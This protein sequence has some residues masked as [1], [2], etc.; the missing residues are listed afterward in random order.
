MRGVRWAALPRLHRN[1]R[2]HVCTGTAAAT[3]A[4]GLRSHICTGRGLA[5]RCHICTG[6]RLAAAT[7]EPGQDV[8]IDCGALIHTAVEVDVDCNRDAVVPGGRV[9]AQMWAG[10]SPLAWDK[11]R[12]TE[13][14]ALALSGTRSTCWCA[15]RWPGTIHPCAAAHYTLRN[16]RGR[17]VFRTPPATRSGRVSR[18]ACCMLCMHPATR[19]CLL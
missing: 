17:V 7:S 8:A 2:C 9:P 3:S 13:A 10:Q 12:E 16:V 4:P 11:S 14:L 15:G 1:C 6:T 19:L 5:R 18:V